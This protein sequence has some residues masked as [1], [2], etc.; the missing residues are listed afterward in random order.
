MDKRRRLEL[1]LR[2][3][4]EWQGM[5]M[6]RR[7]TRFSSAASTDDMKLLLD[8][9]VIDMLH[10]PMRTNEKV[11]NLLYEE[12][13]N[14]KT[15][16]DVNGKRRVSTKKKHLVGD[17]AVG[18]Q[19]AKMLVN[20]QGLP[21]LLRGVVTLY[22]EEGNGEFYTVSYDEQHTEEL[23]ASQYREAN[24]FA[25]LLQKD[26]INEEGRQHNVEKTIVA[27]R[28]E[29][30][31]DVIRELGS[32]GSSWSHHWEE[33]KT[34]CLKK[35]K[36]PFDQSKKIFKEHHL[37]RLQAAV[38]VAVS[39]ARPEHR[40]NWHE[41]VEHYVEMMAS[42]TKSDNFE[43]LQIEALD[44]T[45]KK[46]YAVLIKIAGIKACT[47]YFH[48][49]GSGHVI[50]L[51]RKYGNLWRWR[52]EGAES[53]NGVLSLRYN[54]FN[55]RGGNKGNSANKDMKQKCFPFQV[56]GAWMARLTMWQL[57]LGEALFE[58][59]IGCEGD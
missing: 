59:D 38:D 50:W 23:C 32:L 36:L 49:L 11:L 22:T 39:D 16:N 12:I 30:L 57:G 5:V 25:Q 31:T 52:N 45:I 33:G 2:E 56:L 44:A 51:T 8:R 13:L 34:K 6:Y 42:L 20:D 46:C 28:L 35:I 55:N 7:D 4:E 27:P 37:P 54:K 3:E 43:A 41:F 17:A 58:A 14:G 24:K 15:K 9:T 10:L 53:Q 26:N 19:V 1:V 21:E 47:N 40:C 18:Q 48:L 29:Q